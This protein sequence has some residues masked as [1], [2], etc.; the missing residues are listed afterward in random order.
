MKWLFATLVALNLI[1]FAGMLGGK[2]LKRHTAAQQ[3]VSTPVAPPQ[4]QQQQPQ[5]GGHGAARGATRLFLRR[6]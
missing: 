3:A 4:P 1:V 5:I 2:M 6:V